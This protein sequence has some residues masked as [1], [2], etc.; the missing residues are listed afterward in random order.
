MRLR[1]LLKMKCA[2]YSLTSTKAN[3]QWITYQPIKYL[4][5]KVSSRERRT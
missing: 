5:T 4:K 2:N 1:C 3:L